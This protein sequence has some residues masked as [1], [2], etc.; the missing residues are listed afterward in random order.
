ME[1]GLPFTKMNGLGNDFIVVDARTSGIRLTRE[2][3]NRVSDRQTGIGCDQFIILEPP[4]PG[5]DVFMRIYNGAGEEVEACGNATRCIAH[6]VMQETGKDHA[7]IETVAGVLLA[8][9]AAEQGAITVDMGV[10]KLRWDQIPLAEPF[11]DTRAIELQIGPIDAPILH[12]P[13]V[14]NMGNPHA[15]FFTDDIESLD[16]ERIGPMLENHPMF[17]E[18]ANIS[19]VRVESRERMVVRVWE[20]GAGLTRACGTAACAVGV[21]AFRKRLA[22]RRAEVVLPGGPLT[23]EWRER[24]D[25]VLMTGPFEIDYQDVIAAALLNGAA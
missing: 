17:P 9:P 24:D 25:H 6:T 5:S 21:S 13:A 14:A 23:I 10:P 11:H 19:V 7:A 1:N 20:R 16:L 2:Q 8:Y 15:I 3:I 4:R 12:S 18:R 22:E